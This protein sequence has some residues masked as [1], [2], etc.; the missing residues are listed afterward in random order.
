MRA[1]TLVLAV[2]LMAWEPM[3]VAGEFEA[4]IGTIGMR[5]W[6]AGTEL[7]V[8]AAIAAFCVASGWALWNRNPAGPSLA[9]YAVA[10]SAAA[11]VQSLYGSALP[12]QTVPGEQLPFAALAV[13]NALAWILWLRRLRRVQMT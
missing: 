10:L 2:F 11:T 12:H 13:A 7:V 4:A 5:G 6:W 3:R 8:H 9:P 1:L